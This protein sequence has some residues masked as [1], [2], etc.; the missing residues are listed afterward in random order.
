MRALYFTDT[1]P[2]QVN[3]VSVV[4]HLS[5]RALIH[6]GWE[7]GVIAPRYPAAMP[8]EVFGAADREILLA[9]PSVAAPRY[10]EVRLMAPRLGRVMD[11]V[12]RFRPDLIHCATE[13]VAGWLGQRAA[14][15]LGCPLIT[16]YHTDFGRYMAA[17]GTPWLAG[18]ITRYLTGFHRRA[19][20]TLTPS[21][22]T[23][24][25]LRHRGLERATVWGCGVDADRFHPRHRSLEYRRTLGV[26]PG[27]LFLHV[28]RLAPEKNVGVL[29]DAFRRCR[30][31]LGDRVRL[32]VAGDG[33]SRA[34]LTR[35]SGPGVSFLGYLD[36]VTV[37]PRLYASADGFVFASET[38]T[39]GL[40]VLEAMA[41]GLPVIATPAGGVGDHLRHGVNGLAFGPGDAER[42][43][44]SMVELAT[45]PL[46]HGS[47]SDGARRT[48]LALSWDAEFD[49]LDACYRETVR[50]AGRPADAA[51]V[52]PEMVE[53][54]LVEPGRRDPLGSRS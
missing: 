53:P 39:L 35:T 48:A 11:A 4:T 5:V 26:D 44:A 13:F 29:L 49:R 3:G 9:L 8:R 1:Y 34:E 52:E 24:T 25:E 21:L 19:A 27:F 17:Y 30:A 41:S 7:V 36:R 50:L 12:R 2:P 6:R 15:A 23:A 40:V 51:R 28:G 37:L 32:I 14:R 45:L 47:L 22:A 31:E 42:M 33:P 54:A 16:S 46:L 43:A 20:R 38:E 18:P 10:P